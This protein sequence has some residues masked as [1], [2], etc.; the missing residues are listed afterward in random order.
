MAS[1]PQLVSDFI[2][3]T[4]IRKPLSPQTFIEDLLPPI[5]CYYATAVLVLIPNTL[6]VR[7]AF[8][9]V[10]L[11]SIFRA[12]TTVDVVKSFDDD[13][14]IHWNQGIVL[15]FTTM[16]MRVLAWSVQFEPYERAPR[17]PSE[18]SADGRIA[19][20]KPML[21]QDAEPSLT[22]I[23]ASGVD[24]QFDATLQSLSK[25]AQRNCK[26]VV[27]SIINTVKKYPEARKPPLFEEM[28]SPVFLPVTRL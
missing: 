9:P 3:S 22:A 7:L 16:A 18:K 1:W 4:D 13:R 6:I 14:L 26:A 17:N 8:M 12:S 24:A 11:W 5:I 21:P 20:W 15:V 27:D 19:R 23:L 10:T 2:P 25:I 28:L